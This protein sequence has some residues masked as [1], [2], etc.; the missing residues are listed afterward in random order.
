MTDRYLKN[1]SNDPKYRYISPR[2]NKNREK[3]SWSSLFQILTLH[4][5]KPKYYSDYID[6]ECYY[7]WNEPYRVNREQLY[8]TT[9][10]S[11]TR[12]LRV[13]RPFSL[14]TGMVHFI[15][16]SNIHYQYVNTQVDNPTLQWLLFALF[17][18]V[19]RVP[20]WCTSEYF[21]LLYF[22]KLSAGNSLNH[23]SLE[24]IIWPVFAFSYF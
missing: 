8:L 10:W 2:S 5:T 14:L 22:L 23:S 20:R 12:D 13:P 17:L 9:A 7:V 6:S 16:V 4:G 19:L 15:P 21:F 1:N 3:R 24:C 11:R 18:F